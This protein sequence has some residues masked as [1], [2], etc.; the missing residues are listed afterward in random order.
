MTW[1]NQNGGSGSGGPRNLWPPRHGGGN[2]PPDL[3]DLLR[4]AQARLHRLMPGG[5]PAGARFGTIGLVI[6]A[7]WLLSGTYIVSPDE[8]GVV[9][10][11]GKFVARTAPGINYHLPWPI[12]VAYTPKV[13]RENQINVGYRTAGEAGNTNSAQD[14]AA[15]A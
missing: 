5:L 11:F 13:T 9:L 7:V 1:D 8:Q 12:E 10:R 14:I 6:A 4:R 2:T 3:E 15:E